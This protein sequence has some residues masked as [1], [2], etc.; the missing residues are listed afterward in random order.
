MRPLCL[1][2]EISLYIKNATTN[3]TRW[4]QIC[5]Q[6]PV[7][8]IHRKM[9]RKLSWWQSQPHC[10]VSISAQFSAP[11]VQKFGTIRTE[12]CRNQAALHVTLFM[13]NTSNWKSLHVGAFSLFCKNCLEKNNCDRF[14]TRKK[15]RSNKVDLQGKYKRKCNACLNGGYIYICFMTLAKSLPNQISEPNFLWPFLPL[16]YQNVLNNEELSWREKNIKKNLISEI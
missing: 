9:Q 15:W 11:F 4:I 1:V 14:G 16:F 2:S 12:W 5:C 13:Y 10:P 8:R 7:F 3:K 6:S